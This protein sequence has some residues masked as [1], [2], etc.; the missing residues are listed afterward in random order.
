M[1]PLWCILLIYAVLH[2][3]LI[4]TFQFD[5]INDLWYKAY[6]KTDYSSDHNFTVEEV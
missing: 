4:Y 6:N 2:L 5:V 3:V 1:Y